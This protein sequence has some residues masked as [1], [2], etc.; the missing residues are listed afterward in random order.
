MILCA[1]ALGSPFV[2]QHSGV[3]EA[4][5]LASLGIEP[6]VDLPQVGRNLQDHLFG[7]LK[8]ELRDEAHSLN[9]ILGS[10]PRMGIEA[11]KWLLFGTGWL[12]VTS[13]HL[14]AFFESGPGVDRADV[15]MSMRPFTFT[16]RPS[17]A[18]DID[19]FRA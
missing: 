7:H 6:V 5:H 1:G 3:G 15:Q 16:M 18:A 9:A 11:L 19:D 13:S 4:E 14:T 2:L 8:F 17:G 10:T 12:N